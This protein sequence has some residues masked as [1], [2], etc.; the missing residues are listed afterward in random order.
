M[1]DNNSLQ[2]GIRLYNQGEYEKSL[3]AFLALPASSDF[4][5]T[6]MAYYIGLCYTQLKH[7]EDAMLYLEQVVTSEES[8][9]RILQCRLLLAMI[10]CV[11]G[12][13]KLADYELEKLLKDGYKPAS[14]YAAMAYIAYEKGEVSH[15]L[16]LYESA[17]RL[18]SENLTALNGMGYV[19]ATENKDL[20]RALNCCK[21]ALEYSPNSSAVLDS[22]GFVYLK[23]GLV[24]DALHYLEQA[25]H[26]DNNNSEIAQHLHEA[27]VGEI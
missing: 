15:A 26:I 9:E 8:N 7:Y 6:D 11:S 17:L 1:A 21:K 4:S 13:V 27:Q 25:A 18:D 2:P 12:R 24:K 10:Y 20:M 16:E 19:L 22:L 23:M 3:A 5:D 14:V